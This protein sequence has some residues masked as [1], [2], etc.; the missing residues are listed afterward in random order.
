MVGPAAGN[1][2]GFERPVQKRVV[3]VVHVHEWEDPTAAGAA[4]TGDGRVFIFRRRGW[5]FGRFGALRSIVG[6]SKE[7]CRFREISFE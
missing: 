1:L 5:I 7:E 3:T 6:R 2:L 4:V